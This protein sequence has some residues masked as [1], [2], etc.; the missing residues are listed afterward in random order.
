VALR[1]NRAIVARPS[2]EERVQQA[3]R[4]FRSQGQIIEGLIAA[5]QGRQFEGRYLELYVDF[6]P[7]PALDYRPYHDFIP[8]IT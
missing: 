2:V 6:D 3:I 5:R 4:A 8:N 7:R 1:A